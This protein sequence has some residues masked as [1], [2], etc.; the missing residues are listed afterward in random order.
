MEWFWATVE[1]EQEGLALFK[2]PCGKERLPRLSVPIPVVPTTTPSLSQVLVA[3]SL[4]Y[5]T[6]FLGFPNKMAACPN[7]PAH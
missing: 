1:D 3:L 7:P 6:W 2:E 5:H 4:T